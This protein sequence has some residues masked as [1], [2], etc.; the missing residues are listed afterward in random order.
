MTYTLDLSA[1]AQALINV[2]VTSV[3]VR[4]ETQGVHVLRAKESE[5]TTVQRCQLVLVQ[6]LGDGK[7]SRV[8]ETNVGIGIA[9]TYFTH[10]VIIGGPKILDQIR[11]VCNV[12]QEGDENARI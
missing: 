7:Y 1:L 3:S 6:S 2:R 10:A 5:V 12:G 8:H 4:Q 11:T 9:V